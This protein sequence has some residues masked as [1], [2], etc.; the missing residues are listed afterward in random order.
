MRGL[1]VSSL[2][3]FAPC[4]LYPAIPKAEVE[5]VSPAGGCHRRRVP[6]PSRGCWQPVGCSWRKAELTVPLEAANHPSLPWFS[7]SSLG[8]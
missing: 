1:L 6:A 4:D 2:N 5:Q 8:T 3:G 7:Q